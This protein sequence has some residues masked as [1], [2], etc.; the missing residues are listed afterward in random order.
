MNKIFIFAS[1]NKKVMS[2]RITVDLSEQSWLE[3]SEKQF[4]AKK[5]GIKAPSLSKMVADMV[6]ESLKQKKAS[7]N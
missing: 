7:Q 3:L 1:L 4:E 6:D 2:R 5:Q